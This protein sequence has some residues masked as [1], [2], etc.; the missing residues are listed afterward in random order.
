MLDEDDDPPGPLLALDDDPPLIPGLLLDEDEPPLMPGL[1]DEDEPLA[2][3]LLV[4]PVAESGPLDDELEE[5]DG[6]GAVAEDDEEPPGTMIVSFSLVTVEV[7]GAPPGT[8][9][10]VSLRSHAERAK[11]PTKIN[12]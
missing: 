7:G 2:P 4:P 11:A 1:L 10:V 3:E 12:R 6:A 8:T 5:P 9:A